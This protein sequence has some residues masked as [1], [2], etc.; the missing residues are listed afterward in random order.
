VSR[1]SS[2]APMMYGVRLADPAPLAATGLSL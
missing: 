2:A 1:A